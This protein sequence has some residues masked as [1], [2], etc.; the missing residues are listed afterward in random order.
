MIVLVSQDGYVKRTP[1]TVKKVHR[2]SHGTTMNATW[3]RILKEPEGDNDLV[4]LTNL[5]GIIRFP[6]KELMPMGEL[7]HGVRAIKLQ[8]YESIQ[9]AIIKGSA[10]Q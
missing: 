8:D 1:L 6:L 10:E 9:D 5:G 7:A 4:L 3:F 2:G